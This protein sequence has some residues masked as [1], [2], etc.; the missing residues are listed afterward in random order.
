[1]SSHVCRGK[2]TYIWISPDPVKV[3]YTLGVVVSVV[4]FAK[5][6]KRVGRKEGRKRGVG[7]T[8]DYSRSKK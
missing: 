7:D 2:T 1:M 8:R 4:S 6:S 5:P 3:R